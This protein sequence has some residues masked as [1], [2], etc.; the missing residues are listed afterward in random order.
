VF[1]RDRFDAALLQ[2][3]RDAGAELFPARMTAM[4]RTGGCWR[5]Q[6]ASG[7]TLEAPWLLG[8]DG[9]GGLTRK[10]VFRPF[11]RRQ[12]SIAAGSYVDGVKSREIVIAFLERPS[13]YL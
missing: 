7:A 9:A 11:A 10:Q 12:L 1:S 8:A 13:G 6:T 5:I 4:A 3:A 2:R